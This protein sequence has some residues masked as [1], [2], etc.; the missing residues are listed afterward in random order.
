MRN[1]HDDWPI[2]TESSRAPDYLKDLLTVALKN[3]ATDLYL[4]PKE[5]AYQLSAQGPAGLQSLGGLPEDFA[6]SL[7]AL[8]KY[9]AQVDLAEFRRPQ[10]GR[11]A[12]GD[13]FVRLS[14][15]GD[16]LG[17]ES[18]VLRLIGHQASAA[19][20]ADLA[21][22]QALLASKPRA[23]L[24]VIA[25]P[26]G[27][28]KTTTLYAL[29]NEWAK[30]RLV[31]TVEDPVELVQ[32]AFLQLQVNETAKVGYQ[33]LIKVALRHRPD[34]LVIGEI[35]DA[36][37]AAATLQAALSGHLVLT[38]VHANSAEQV[39]LRLVDLGLPEK[40]VRAALI[41]SLYQR[42]E[43]DANGR[44]QATFDQKDWSVH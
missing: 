2:L 14:S 11:F 33:D 15:V 37:T 13:A 42:L 38:T 26:T 40:L 28:G 23:G 24:F 44:L 16:F 34:I 3:D 43:R 27:S 35:R 22:W 30:D 25:G 4:L 9:R 32:P 20:F 7:M 19:R 29:L 41:T 8:L 39:L 17:R 12:F 18:M 5:G 36:Q 21:A 31:L 1:Q 10:L 6:R